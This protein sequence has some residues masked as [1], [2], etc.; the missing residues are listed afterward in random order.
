MTVTSAYIFLKPKL[1]EI[2]D[3]INNTRLEHGQNYGDNF[4][5]KIE[6]RCNNNFSDKL[7]KTLGIIIIVEYKKR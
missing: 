4:C 5:R 7:K 2:T 3:N 6:V 1:N